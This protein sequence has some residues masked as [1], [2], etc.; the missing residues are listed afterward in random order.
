MDNFL[1]AIQ[2]IKGK[3]ILAYV[4]GSISNKADLY[5]VVIQKFQELYNHIEEELKI[6]NNT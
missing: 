3:R 6:L 4:E 2:S 5:T 1:N